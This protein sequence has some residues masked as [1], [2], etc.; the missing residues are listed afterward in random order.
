[1][2]TKV[3]VYSIAAM[4]LTICAELLFSLWSSMG[5]VQPVIGHIIKVISFWC[6]YQA[7]IETTLTEP[8]SVL[9]QAY[10][11][12]DAIPHPAIV[13]DNNGTVS[14]VNRAAVQLTGKSIEEL[15]HKPVHHHFHL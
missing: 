1:M 4:I 15:I 2:P 13:V 11:S 12:Y 6:I 8:F 7:I 10:S 14:Q 3:F 9:S 5:Q